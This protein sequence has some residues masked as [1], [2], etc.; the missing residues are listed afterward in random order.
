MCCR[1]SVEEL[2]EELKPLVLYHVSQRKEKK[3]KKDKKGEK[4]E[5]KE[6]VKATPIVVKAE[7]EEKALLELPGL[8][9]QTRNKNFNERVCLIFLFSFLLS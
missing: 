1:K 9:A 5:K 8:V 4:G 6:K 2:E 3:G 7:D